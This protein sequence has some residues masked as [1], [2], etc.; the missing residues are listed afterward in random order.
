VITATESHHAAGAAFDTLAAEYDERFTFSAIG[1]AQREVVWSRAAAIFR[2]GDRILELNCGTG[3]DAF[4]LARKG[5][6]LTACDASMRMIDRARA[7]QRVEAPDSRITFQVL[8]TEHIHKL[9]RKPLFDGV[10]SNFSGLN[11]VADLPAVAQEI[12]VRVRPGAKLL[13]CLST[14]FC[15]WEALHYAAQGK[16]QKA[17][18]RW[19]GVSFANFD[20]HAFPVYYPTVRALRKSFGPEFKL[21]TVTGIGIATPPSYVEKWARK[22]PRLLSATTRF[23]SLVCDLPVFRNIGDHM[24]VSLERV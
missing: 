23:D 20:D 15:L 17:A 24:L 5:M 14:R 10:F 19:R 22:H 11:C 12:A 2:F 16:F 6:R 3:E 9:P 7:R 8:A 13:L 21:R 4:F 1:R 18:R